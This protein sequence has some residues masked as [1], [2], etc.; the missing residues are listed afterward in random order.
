MKRRATGRRLVCA[1]VGCKADSRRY[2]VAVAREAYAV[3]ALAAKHGFVVLT[4]GLSGVMERAAAGARAAGGLT[5]GLLPGRDHA[6]GNPSLE[7]VLPSGLGIARNCVVAA[8]CDVMIA[9]PGGTGTLEEM[10][11]ASDYGRTII[12]Y[13][14]WRVPGAVRVPLGRRH[15]VAWALADYTRQ[16]E[17]DR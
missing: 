2:S 17:N 5:I 9:L 1:I 11:F 15:D 10:C 3:G 6:D 13:G 4:G 7:V 16:K 12:S 14:S 8:A